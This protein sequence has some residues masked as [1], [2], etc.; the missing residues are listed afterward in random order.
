MVLVGIAARRGVKW[1]VAIVT[2]I[3]VLGLISIFVWLCVQPTNLPN[4]NPGAG[5]AMIALVSTWLGWRHT[6]VALPYLVS[7]DR[8]VLFPEYRRDAPGTIA[9]FNAWHKWKTAFTKKGYKTLWMLP[10]GAMLLLLVQ[11]LPHT[12]EIKDV[13]S[14][15]IIT[16]LL[17]RYGLRHITPSAAEVRSD[18]NRPPILLL[19]S[20]KDETVRINRFG[21]LLSLIP[22][23]F[24]R[25]RAD[26]FLEKTLRSYGPVTAIGRPRETLPSLGAAR[27]YASDDHWMSLVETRIRE[28]ELL[29]AILGGTKGFAWEMS[30]ILRLSAKQKLILIV[31]PLSRHRKSHRWEDISKALDVSC[32]LPP[33]ALIISW[34]DGNTNVVTARRGRQRLDAYFLAL[35]WVLDAR[36]VQ[37]REAPPASSFRIR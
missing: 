31:P 1:G 5:I 37:F 4:Q 29:I 34:H 19:R 35:E 28:S 11:T 18:D 7:G 25:E 13:L 6:S 36:G 16:Y 22:K 15:I 32:K 3:V 9:S 23:V 21:L 27:E 14:G 10:A 2:A 17:F 8:N 24:K 33:R 20:F 30:S 26:E 12:S